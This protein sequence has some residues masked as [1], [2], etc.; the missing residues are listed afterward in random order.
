[1]I[2]YLVIDFI[3]NLFKKSHGKSKWCG[4]KVKVVS[5]EHKGKKGTVLSYYLPTGAISIIRSK[6]CFT[7]NEKDIEKRW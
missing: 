2:G 6:D 1:M 4:K 5:G 3:F 7:C